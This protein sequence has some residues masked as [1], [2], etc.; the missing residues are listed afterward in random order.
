MFRFDHMHCQ[1]SSGKTSLAIE[2]RWW[3]YVAI[4]VLFPLVG[5]LIEGFVYPFNN[6]YLMIDGIPNR[7]LYFSQ[8]DIIGNY[9]KHVAI[10]NSAF[11]PLELCISWP[12]RTRGWSHVPADSLANRSWRWATPKS[13]GLRRRTDHFMPCMGLSEIY[14]KSSGLSS[15]SLVL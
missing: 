8:K 11:W 10:S 5:W 14:P 2:R 1:I 3:P 13:A 12:K 4:D 6:R 7:P 15:C 9:W